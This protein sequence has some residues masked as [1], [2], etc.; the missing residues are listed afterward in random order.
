M[1]HRLNL[2]MLEKY[3]GGWKT[4]K[5]RLKKREEI[6]KFL[7]IFLYFLMLI[8]LNTPFICSYAI[9]TAYEL[10]HVYNSYQ[11]FVHSQGS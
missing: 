3:P 4:I 5:M 10:I 11:I 2:C 6:G 7:L 9:R 8:A 1:Y